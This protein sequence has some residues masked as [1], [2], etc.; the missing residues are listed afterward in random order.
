MVGLAGVYDISAHYN[1]EAKRRVQ[2]VSP[3]ARAM[4]GPTN[5]SHVSPTFLVRSLQLT[6]TQHFPSVLLVHGD[7]DTVVPILSSQELA[8]ALESSGMTNIASGEKFPHNSPGVQLVVVPNA[9]HV[10][11]VMAA[12]DISSSIC[13]M[14]LFSALDSLPFL[15]SSS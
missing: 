10:D 3:M 13:H 15:F 5:F 4:L 9:T 12:M 8:R 14:P 1:H 6:P 11:P 7:N 2:F